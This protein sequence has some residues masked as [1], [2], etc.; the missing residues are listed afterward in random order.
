MIYQCRYVDDVWLF[1]KP[2][3]VFNVVDPGLVWLWL[4][5]NFGVDPELFDQL[6]KV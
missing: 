1:V 2:A 3:I 6:V 4:T 5:L